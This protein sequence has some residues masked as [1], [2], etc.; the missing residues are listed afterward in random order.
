MQ[1]MELKTKSDTEAN[2]QLSFAGS[3]SSSSAGLMTFAIPIW[4]GWASGLGQ[5]QMQKSNTAYRRQRL[6]RSRSCTHMSCRAGIFKV[7]YMTIFLLTLHL[8]EGES[9]VL[10]RDIL[11]PHF[12]LFWRALTPPAP[13]SSEQSWGAEFWGVALHHTCIHSYP[14]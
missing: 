2:I 8:W 13:V 5:V 7:E 14:N 6:G 4:F 9:W 3:L 12:L 11:L 1:H 10:L